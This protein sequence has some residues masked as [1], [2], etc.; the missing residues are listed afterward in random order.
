ML[1]SVAAQGQQVLN[2]GIRLPDV[3]PPRDV[4]LTNEPQPDPPYLVHPPDVI[5][6][7]LGRQLFVDDFL[8][9]STDLRREYHRPELY[10]GNPVLKGDRPW[11]AGHAMPFSD[12]VFYDPKDHLFKIWYRG[13]GATLYAISPDG[14]H[15]EK[16]LLD[17]QPGT[18]TVH[19]GQH[20]SSTV[21]LD[22]DE[23]DAR[24]RY[25]MG[26]SLGHNRPFVLFESADG[27]HWSRPS[28]RA[29]RAAIASRS[30]RIPS[31]TCGYS[32]Y[33]ITIG[34]RHPDLSGGPMNRLKITGIISDGSA[35]TGRVRILR[36]E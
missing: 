5:P 26:Y 2:N 34:S 16:P 6:I 32:A 30:S 15:W 1:V 31:V 21:W 18:N 22:L 9:E 4:A 23:K 14:V 20:D 11:E 8:I 33:E 7:D 36:P 13:D 3:R 29:S 19:I 12:G 25:K 27:I 35:V 17:I 28:P 24:R 10:P